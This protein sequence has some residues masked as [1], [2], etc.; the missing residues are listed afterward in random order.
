VDLISNAGVTGSG[1]GETASRIFLL[2]AAMSV[3][4]L[5][6]SAGRF[7]RR[8]FIHGSSR[9]IETELRGR[10]F[11]HLLALSYDFYQENKL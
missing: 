2:C 3:S 9:R 11:D 8:Y 4:M 5:F 10:I 6:I 7:L 1:G